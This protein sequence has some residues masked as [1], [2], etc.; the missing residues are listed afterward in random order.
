MII[1]IPVFVQRIVSSLLTPVMD[2]FHA[3]AWF[4]SNRHARSRLGEN[5]ASRVSGRSALVMQGIF[6][7]KTI[8]GISLFERLEHL[9]QGLSGP[10]R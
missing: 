8:V 5:I 10:R 3:K 1:S 7:L 2:G 6:A 9:A 4:S